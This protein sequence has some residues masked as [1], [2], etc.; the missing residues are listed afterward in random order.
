VYND[1][2]F[3]KLVGYILN[4]IENGTLSSK[5][6]NRAD[7][8][9]EDSAEI[10]EFIEDNNVTNLTISEADMRESV[11]H[12]LESNS[13]E[14]LKDRIKTIEDIGDS[15]WKGRHLSEYGW[16]EFEHL[17]GDLFK[18]EGYSTS[19]TQKSAD[20]GVDVWANK[21]G[22][23]TAIQVKKFSKQNT[24]GREPLQKVASAIAKG[25]A[26]KVVVV[27]SSSFADTAEQYADDF[28]SN[29][30]LVDRAELLRRLNKS[31]VV[32]PE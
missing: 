32:P 27:T 20:M 31:N 18:S 16:E 11:H 28:G 3:S 5:K 30:Q 9:L 24:V 25:D 14:P 22:D 7:K 21:D 29:M 19:V 17:V 12:A 4:E 8:V 26:D 6:V 23:R 10:V 13:N 1:Y 15:L 2:R